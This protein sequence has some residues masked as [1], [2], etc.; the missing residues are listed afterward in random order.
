MCAFCAGLL[1]G[2]GREGVHLQRAQT[3]RP[4]RNLSAAADALW[5]KVW[6]GERQDNSGLKQG[7]VDKWREEKVG[8]WSLTLNA[9]MPYLFKCSQK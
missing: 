4:V 3:H 1:R 8:V 9:R 2:G 7:A 6:A 5:G